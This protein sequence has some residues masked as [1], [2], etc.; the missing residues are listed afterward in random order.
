MA[1]IANNRISFFV[2]SI[3]QS[4]TTLVESLR[5]LIDNSQ[6]G[7][8]LGELRHQHSAVLQYLIDFV[9]MVYKPSSDSEHEVSFLLSL[10]AWH[11]IVVTFLC[12]VF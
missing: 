1:V 10:V 6:I 2:V 12:N 11:Y 4:S 8:L 3:A 5:D 7:P 9:H